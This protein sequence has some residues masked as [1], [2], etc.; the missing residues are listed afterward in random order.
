VLILGVGRV[1]GRWET[2][3][4][5]HHSVIFVLCSDE[6]F[7]FLRI[8]SSLAVRG[9][10]ITVLKNFSVDGMGWSID[11]LSRQRGIIVCKFRYLYRV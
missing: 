8:V 5:L 11:V 4:E 1:E 6:C 10:C 2:C 3:I 9:S 7:D